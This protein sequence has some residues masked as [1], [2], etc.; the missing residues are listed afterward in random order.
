MKTAVV[1]FNL[2]GPD[3][4]SSVK[5]FL[6]NLFNDPAIINWPKPLRVPLAKLI[7]TA[8]AG[9]ARAMYRQMGGKSPILEQTMAQAAALEKQLATGGEYK[10]FVSM[11]YWHPQSNAVAKKV[12]S[13][14]PDRILLLPLYPQYSTATTGSSFADWDRVCNEIGLATPTARIC[15]Y[16][17]ARAFIAG[18]AKLIRDVY[19]KA[20]ERG[21]PRVLFSAHGLPESVVAAGDPYAWQ[22]AKTVASIVQVLAIDDLDY[23]VCYQSKVGF[24]PW[25]GPSTLE[26]IKEA[27]R[28]NLPVLVVPVSFVSE[29]VETLVELDKIYRRQAEKHGANGYWR[30]PALGTEPLFIEA[31]AGLCRENVEGVHSFAPGRQCPW[32]F[33]QCPCGAETDAESEEDDAAAA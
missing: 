19:W 8:R 30:A 16:P 18:H 23:A 11:R 2:G 3:N 10:V 27:G 4:L 17:A 25:L 28:E 12:R 9:K 21:K 24:L 26:E 13:Y 32:E 6:F 15:C 1:L 7:S 33:S 20:A 5:P 22:V 31:L 14:A 29:H